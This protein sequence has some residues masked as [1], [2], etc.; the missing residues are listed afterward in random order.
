MKHRTR[1]QHGVSKESISHSD[2]MPLYGSG[3]GSG[4]GVINCHGN[5]EFRISMYDNTQPRYVMKSPDARNEQ[6]QQGVSFFY[7]NKLIQT[8]LAHT[9]T[10]DT[11]KG[12]TESINFWKR[13]L[14]LQ[15]EH[16]HQPNVNSNSWLLIL[17]LTLITSITHTKP[18][19]S[20]VQWQNNMGAA[21]C[22][23]RI[24]KDTTH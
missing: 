24:P 8:F 11:L 23:T 6:I 14:K 9:T 10:T 12:S 5:N 21:S 19:R 18:S 7:D 4:A 16:W 2:E 13:E 3:Q 17:T 1:I 20:Y 15:E 22:M